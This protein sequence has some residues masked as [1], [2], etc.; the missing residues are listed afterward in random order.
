MRIVHYLSEIVLR[1]GGVVRAVLDLCAGLAARDH[2]VHLLCFDGTDLPAPWLQQQAAG[3]RAPR[4]HMLAAPRFPKP[5]RQ[6]RAA[7]VRAASAAMQGASA[8]HVHGPWEPT[9]L[10]MTAAARKLGVPTVVSTHGMLDD[11]SMAQGRARK[12]AFLKL[13]SGPM[14][15]RASCVLCTAEG[16]RRQV[17][18]WTRYARVESLPM[19]MDLGGFTP[20]PDPS[21][22]QSL[23]DGV[24]GEGPLVLFLSRLHPK[25]GLELLLDAA[26]L[27]ASR[28]VAFRLAIAGAEDIA[29]PGY[30]ATLRGHAERAGLLDRAAFVG[31]VSSPVKES[32]LAAACVHA[33]P[34][35]QENWGFSLLES[36][37]AGTPVVTTKGVD[38][39]PELESSGGASIAERTPQAMA[40]ALE[41]F[42]LNPGLARQ[43]GAQARAWALEFLNPDR[44]LAMYE[45]LYASLTPHG[46]ARAL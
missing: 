3:A 28:H 18:Q 2:D 14:L 6:F 21:G 9:N 25:K 23:M 13:A 41:Q 26:A 29:C 42:L 7:D 30:A 34:T 37:A 27:L 45:S 11:W 19:L 17:R 35:H 12:L 20:A 39:W 40:Q 46:P 8:L 38:I 1:H 22:A 16:E 4:A 36:L 24:P 31:Q 33:L 43:R 32:L 5:I 15:D 10:Q 44:V